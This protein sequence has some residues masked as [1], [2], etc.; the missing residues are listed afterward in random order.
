MSTSGVTDTWRDDE[1]LRLGWSRCGSRERGE[2]PPW[3]SQCS[4][5]CPAFELLQSRVDFQKLWLVDG[6]EKLGVFS[7]CL[8]PQERDGAVKVS[9]SRSL[10]RGPAV[11]KP[12]L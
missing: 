1:G 4:G 6:R 9:C 7:W 8:F 5:S 11:L 3:Q 10:P 12:Q 2:R